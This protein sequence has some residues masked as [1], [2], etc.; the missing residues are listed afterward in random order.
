MAASVRGALAPQNIDARPHAPVLLDW[1]EPAVAAALL[2]CVA[3][4]LLAAAVLTAILSRRSPFVRHWRVG[5]GGRPIGVLKLRTMW[6]LTPAAGVRPAL[7][8]D[9]FSSEIPRLPKSAQDARVTSAFARFCRRYSIDE[10]PQLVNVIR[11]EM[12]IVGPRPITEAELASYYGAFAP[13]V[14]SVRPGITGLWQTRGRS[15][16]TFDER[17][18]CDLELVR[19]LSPSLYASI[20]LRTAICVLKGASAW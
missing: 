19:N 5:E 16:L 20:L 15:S 11:R 7:I 10:L 2:V 4:L 13:E 14:L 8:E 3:P 12:A 17:L 18:R 1:C 9:V 6:S